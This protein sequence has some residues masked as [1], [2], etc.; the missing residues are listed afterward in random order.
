MV[1]LFIPDKYARSI[2]PKGFFRKRM[3]GRKFSIK[4]E[5][6]RALVLHTTLAK[7]DIKKSLSKV[8][9][10]YTKKV[11]KLKEEKEPRPVTTA[12][13]DEKLLKSRVENLVNWNE[14][15]RLLEK[16]KGMPY[17]WLPS[18]SLEPRPEHQLKYGK[19]FIVGEGEFPGHEYGCKCGALILTDEE[20]QASPYLSL[21]QKN[22]L[23]KMRDNQR[24]RKVFQELNKELGQKNG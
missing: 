6:L 11:E 18:S 21:D 15:E 7:R 2:L 8:V 19:V 23:E 3:I 9:D 16:Y 20:A 5:L 13:N 22:K 1:E 4:R 17:V 10:F 12:V 24:R 14:S